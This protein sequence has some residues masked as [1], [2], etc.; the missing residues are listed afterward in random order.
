MT[1]TLTVTLLAYGL[2]LWLGLF[3]LVRNGLLRKAAVRLAGAGLVAYALALASDLLATHTVSFITSNWLTRLHW[4]LVALPALFWAGALLHLLPEQMPG[5]ARWLAMWS[6]LALPAAALL[7]WATFAGQAVMDLTFGAPPG[8]WSY[9]LI[10]TVIGLLLLASLIL[11]VYVYARA[12]PRRPLGL[13]LLATLFFSLGNGLLLLRLAGWP[14]DWM[15]LAMGADLVVLGLCLAMW[16]AFDEGETWLPEMVRALAAAALPAV[17]LGGLVVW[18]AANNGGLNFVML[19]LLLAVLTAAIATE[20]LADPLQSLLDR[21]VFARWPRLQQ[22]RAVLRAVAS[23][24]PRAE[25]MD[26]APA[27]DEAELARLTRRALSRL[28]DLPALAAS[29]LTQLP[30]IRDRLARRGASDTVLERAA[31]LR[32]VLLEG[33]AGLKPRGGQAFGAADEWRHYNA[34]YF[35]YVVGLKPYSRE[36]PSTPL[37]LASAEARAWFQSS[38]PERTL[39]NW[40]TAAARVIAEGLRTL[41][42]ATTDDGRQTTRSEE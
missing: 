3:L 21:V 8:D 18:A 33:I 2:A 14:R 12:Q 20:V 40:Q 16:D 11:A 17:L 25:A 42:K 9:W 37:D 24:L 41:E 31:E 26:T 38:V 19:S 6:T 32:A 5:R 30:G 28:G 10:V 23:A 22:Q 34:L 39:H 13:A 15:V 36:T 7:A 29:P 4:L 35:P 1:M 27:R